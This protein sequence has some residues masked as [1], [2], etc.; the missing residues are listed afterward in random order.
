MSDQSTEAQTLARAVEGRPRTV[1]P[2]GDGV[3]TDAAPPAS[4]PWLSSIVTDTPQ[5]YGDLTVLN[6]Q[7]GLLE[8]VGD[9]LGDIA[10]DYLALLDTSTAI[11]EHNG[12]YA[13]GLFSSGWCRFMD[14]SS[15]SLCPD[16]DNQTALQSGQWHCHESCWAIS[17][18][19]IETGAPVDAPCLGGIRLYAIPIRAGDEIVGAINFGYGDP[20]QDVETL[21][22]LAARYGVTVDELQQHAAAYES[23]PAYVIQ[24]A[25][26]RL[27]SSARLLGEITRRSRAEVERERLYQAAQEAINARDEFLSVAAHELRTPITSLRLAA[28]SLLRHLAKSKDLN[29]ERVHNSVTLMDQQSEKL[30]RLIDQ[31]LDFA[32]LDAGRLILERSP[33][34]LAA[35][36]RDIAATL[37]AT[38]E[39]HVLTVETPPA[40]LMDVDALRLEQVITNI[41]TNAVKFSPEGGPIE[42]VLDATRPEGVAISVTDGGLGIPVAQRPHIFDRFVQAHGP[43]TY[44]GMGLGLYISKQIMDLHGGSIEAVFPEAGGTQMVIWLPRRLLQTEAAE[45]AGG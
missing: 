30:R 21:E 34:D 24:V 22:V 27:H 20:P 23:R 38:T 13:L 25:K 29:P 4:L 28:Q 39:Q 17:R 45:G 31:L 2:V 40:L 15:R 3:G 37:Q 43:G 19:A 44:G 12:D 33:S 8:A 1:E 6:H 16:D 9:S 41:V 11:Y 18:Q 35:L 10:G 26:Q 36:L 14:A 7:R 5:P 42:I 32:R